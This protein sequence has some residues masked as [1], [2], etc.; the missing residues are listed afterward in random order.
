MPEREGWIIAV[1]LFTIPE[2]L[3][4]S[5]LE[6]AQADWD[7]SYENFKRFA[8]VVDDDKFKPGEYMDVSFYKDLNY[9]KQGKCHY[10]LQHSFLVSQPIKFWLMFCDETRARW[11]DILQANSKD[12][13]FFYSVTS[14]NDSTISQRKHA[15]IDLKTIVD[16]TGSLKQKIE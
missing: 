7:Y 14:I 12:V 5:K 8:N 16:D 9:G 13:Y 11:Y 3:K 10:K 4:I 2:G 1:S 15:V 6:E